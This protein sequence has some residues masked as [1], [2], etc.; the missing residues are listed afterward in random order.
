MGR[1]IH[2][3]R[4]LAFKVPLKESF[5]QMLAPS[6]VFG[7]RELLDAVRQEGHE[8]GVILD[9][10]YTTRYYGP[11]DLPPWLEQVKIK[12]A[13]QVIPADDAILAFKRAAR[14]FLRDNADN[15]KLIG[16]HCTHGLNRTGYMICRYLIDME[17]MDPGEAIRR[18]N[19]CRGHNI[20]RS[21]Y[22]NDL[23]RG[24]TRSNEGVDD[25]C[26]SG[27]P[28]DVRSGAERSPRNWCRADD[29]TYGFPPLGDPRPYPLQWPRQ[30]TSSQYG[31]SPLG[32]EESRPC[33]WPR[34]QY[35][36]R[37]RPQHFQRPHLEHRQ[38]PVRPPTLHRYVPRWAEGQGAEAHTERENC[39]F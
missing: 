27:S 10:T 24:P 11:G 23:L 12:T 6:Q 22:L 7:P 8:L 16:V 1:R 5:N 31:F 28:A 21:N 26:A 20:E 25:E 17:G 15:D 13:G 9:L 36:Q 37:P 4:F 35:S 14:R 18:F 32:S 3:T 29:G 2:G 33:M 38:S 30:H 19:S 39:W 34:P